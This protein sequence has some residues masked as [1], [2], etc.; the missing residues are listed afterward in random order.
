[1]TTT[2]NKTNAKNSIKDLKKSRQTRKEGEAEE[3]QKGFCQANTLN[4]IMS[5]SRSRGGLNSN[6]E[7]VCPN[8][9]KDIY[10]LVYGVQLT[11]ELYH[12]IIDFVVECGEY[13]GELME[14][15]GDA[16]WDFFSIE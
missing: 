1:M 9:I 11:S 5:I 4:T 10:Y 15:V 13:E 14:F 2:I 3:R 8:T 6:K 12:D 16:E 7:G